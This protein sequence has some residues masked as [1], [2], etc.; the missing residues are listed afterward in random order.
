MA[1]SS[2]ALI[3]PSPYDIVFVLCITMAFLF[4]HLS[5]P[6]YTLLPLLLIGLFI[7]ANLISL[8]FS[9]KDV[10]SATRFFLITFYLIVTWFFLVGLL[11]R[12]NQPVLDVIFSGYITAAV[13]AVVIGTAAYFQLIPQAELFLYFGRAS[14]LFKDANVYGPFLIPAVLYALSQFESRE[15][16]GQLFWLALAVLLSIGV[17]LSF[18]RAAWGNYVISVFMYFVLPPWRSLKDRVFKICLVVLL[19][20]A[21]MLYTLNQSQVSDLL[22]QRIGFHNYDNNRF[23]TQL[24]SIKM[25]IDNPLGIGPRQTEQILNYSTHSLYVRVLTEYGLLGITSF[26]GLLFITVVRSLR[27]NFTLNN[28]SP[29][30]AIVTA[31]LAGILF[32]SFFIDTLHWRHFWLFLALPWIPMLSGVEHETRASSNKVG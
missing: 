18:S 1:L 23:G 9:Y 28:A 20:L 22:S 12:Y 13:I 31:S 19:L 15:G 10:V 8:F 16:M 26:L 6:Y 24:A 29:H 27:Q 32:N 25:V 2:I 3:E 17:L 14:G 11:Q 7:D 4:S 5:F 21:V 30:M